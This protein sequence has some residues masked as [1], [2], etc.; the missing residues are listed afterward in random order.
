MAGSRSRAEWAAALLEHAD[1]RQPP[2]PGPHPLTIQ[3]HGC[4]GLRP[5]MA[6]YTTAA[7]D[8]GIAVLTV[9]SFK[10]RGL[11]RLAATALVCTG[12]ALRGDR[13][14]ADVYA[15]YDWARRQEWVDPARIAFAGWSH[16]AWSIMDALAL[17]ADAGAVTGLSDLPG[18][19][20][21]GLAAAFLVY[22][23]AGYPAL[24]TGRGWN[25]AKPQVS[26]LI[27]E[28][29]Q[30]VGHRLLKRAFDRLE[31]DGVPVERLIFPD[32]NHA[33]DD[34]QPSDPR[35]RYR[36]DLFEQ[37]KAWYVERLKIAFA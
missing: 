3:L 24:T 17:G 9:D 26:A 14:A 4:G 27:C 21:D 16:G 5:F 13:R 11:S 1:L 22:T 35:S 6:G 30:V 12:L 23:Y 33:F 31:G 19:P 25:G 20:L 28:R 34:H 32:A 10:P 37:A 8:A 29:D 36:P 18:D 2:G 7:I 15:L